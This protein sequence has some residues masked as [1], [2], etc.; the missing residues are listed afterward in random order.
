MKHRLSA[1]AALTACL[2]ALPATARPPKDY[3]QVPGT[4]SFIQFYGNAC[5]DLVYDAVQAGGV[6][7]GL[8]AADPKVPDDARPRNQW[9]M[10]IAE[11]RLGAR[12]I[13]PSPYGEIRTRFEMD[14]VG[15]NRPDAGT[16]PPPSGERQNYAHVRQMYGECN[17]WLAGKT[18][19]NFEDPDGS[20][21][22][23]DWEGLLADWFGATRIPQLRH[24]SQLNPRTTLSVALEQ[25]CLV[26]IGGSNPASH[27]ST[28]R[29]SDLPGAVTARLQVA[30]AWGHISFA[31]AY[32]RYSQF[33]DTFV[34]ANTP[35]GAPTAGTT[36]RH[37]LGACSWALA[38]HFQF[39][40]DS[41]VYHLGLGNGQYGAN[42]QDHAA[43]AQDHSVRLVQARQAEVG[44]THFWT[45]KVRSN[46]FASYVGYARDANTGMTGSA[47]QSYRQC[48][49][50]AIWNLT[51]TMQYGVE[52]LYGVARTFDAGQIRNPDLSTTDRVH[53]AK[54]HFQFKYLF[55]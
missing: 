31:G 34:A 23:L 6:M 35:G 32:V 10:T 33:Q 13:T 3:Y 20:P 55:N 2:L 26:D 53:E 16:P 37:T 18:D 9:D 14:F 40:P 24:T 51:A 11:S 12:T 50:N 1:M 46:L 45:P 41:L 30:E 52:C 27:A 39:G 44:Y 15:S 29:G 7:A 22:C 38:G 25:D 47:F 49:G 19:S 21:T 48:G 36:S 8:G 4:E 54:L 28:T 42:L 43:W 5:F 17:G